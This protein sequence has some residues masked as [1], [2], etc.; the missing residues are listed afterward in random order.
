VLGKDL[1]QGF[2]EEHGDLF[3]HRPNLSTCLGLRFCKHAASAFAVLKQSI[4]Q[5]YK[6]TADKTYNCVGNRIIALREPI[7]QRRRKQTA[8]IKSLER[9][10]NIKYLECVNKPTDQKKKG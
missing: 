4:E 8:R 3:T 5:Y 1:A 6:P 2:M 10:R 7:V 9:S